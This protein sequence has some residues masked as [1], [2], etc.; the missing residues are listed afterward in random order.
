[1]YTASLSQNRNIIKDHYVLGF[2]FILQ[3]TCKIVCCIVA[4]VFASLRIPVPFSHQPSLADQKKKR[5]YLLASA[6]GSCC[7]ML[8]KMPKCQMMSMFSVVWIETS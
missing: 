8:V 3:D 4:C 2:V 7:L 6:G 5:H 1:M